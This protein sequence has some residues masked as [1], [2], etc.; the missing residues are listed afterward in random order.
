MCWFRI[1]SRS[2]GIGVSVRVRA[3][4][5]LSI[6]RY[7]IYVIPARGPQTMFFYQPWEAKLSGRKAHF[8]G[9]RLVQSRG[10]DQQS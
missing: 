2:T 6:Y 10:G 3:S 4:I 8:V 9:S 7:I 5:T 1:A